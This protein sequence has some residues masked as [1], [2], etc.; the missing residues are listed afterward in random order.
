MKTLL[1][2]LGSQVPSMEKVKYT[3]FWL[4]P[5]TMLSKLLVD[6]AASRTYAIMMLPGT[7]W[8]SDGWE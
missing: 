5:G 2:G 7:T 4:I 1:L 8:D 3:L 6:S